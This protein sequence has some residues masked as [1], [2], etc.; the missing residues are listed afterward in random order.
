[1]ILFNCLERAI[2]F[3]CDGLTIYPQLTLWG[4]CFR[5][6]FSR[7]RDQQDFPLEGEHDGKA[8]LEMYCY[9]SLSLG[10]PCIYKQGVFH[11]F[12]HS[13]STHTP[14]FYRYCNTSKMILQ[15]ISHIISVSSH[16][17]WPTALQKQGCSAPC[18]HGKSLISL[19]LYQLFTLTTSF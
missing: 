15:V 13:V 12:L 7:N 4:S 19:L 3:Q 11:T 2:L 16:L 6:T 18:N 1:M 17:G 8:M 10:T 9:S 14:F 5:P